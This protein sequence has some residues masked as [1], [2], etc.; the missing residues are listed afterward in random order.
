MGAIMKRLILFAGIAIL[1]LFMFSVAQ[2]VP[3]AD[4]LDPAVLHIGNPPGGNPYLYNGEVQPISPTML[5]ILENGN[6]QPILVNPL[7][8]ILG[9]PNMT[10]ADFTAPTI[11]LSAGTGALGG[12]N[13]FSGIWDPISGYAGNFTSDDVYDFITFIPSGNA[14]NNFDNWKSADIAVN[15]IIASGFGIFVYSLTGTGIT[16]GGTV[17]VT[18]S[19]PLP[20]GTFA[21]AYGQ[22]YRRCPHSYTTPFTEAGLTNKVPEPNT[23]VLLGTGLLGLA[24][25]GRRKFRK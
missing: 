23:M 7:L 11:S 12:V 1:F 22:D 5:T 9:V 13:V 14:S 24:L 10:D 6:G 20:L 3:V 4:P 16:G 19:S 25:Y 21:I 2:A 18:F 17:D 15:N 8:L